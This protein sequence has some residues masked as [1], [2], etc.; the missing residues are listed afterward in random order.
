MVAMDWSPDEDSIAFLVV[1]ETDSTTLQVLDLETERWDTVGSPVID[2]EG[3][4]DI[5]TILSWGR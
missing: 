3:I 4:D 2:V 5:P 1:D